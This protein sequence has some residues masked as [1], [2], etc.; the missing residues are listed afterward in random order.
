MKYKVISCA[1]AVLLISTPVLAQELSPIIVEAGKPVPSIVRSGESFEV[2][3]R[4]RYTDIVLIV[5][6]QMRF[7]DLLLTEDKDG[8]EK[9]PPINVEVSRL[10]VGEI[11][12]VGNED[13][14]FFNVQDFTYSFRIINERKGRYK[15]PSFDFI[16]VEKKAGVTAAEAKEKEE[17]RKF[18]TDEVGIAYVSTIVKPPPL[19]IRDQTRFEGFVSLADKLTYS[20]YG[21]IFLSILFTLIT[22][23]RF[24]RHPRAQKVG[25]KDS[26][27]PSNTQPDKILDTLPFKTRKE[28]VRELKKFLRSPR[29]LAEPSDLERKTVV[30][31]RGL[32]IGELFGEPVQALAS[33][34][35]SEL[36]SKLVNLESKQIKALG[37]VAHKTFLSISNKLQN[38]YEDM[39]SGNLSNLG[40]PKV[41]I[42]ELID[43]IGLIDNLSAA[44]RF[45]KALLGF[46]GQYFGG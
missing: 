11:H 20:A 1:V 25:E 31:L 13:E 22:L 10:V 9:E 38:F 45:R 12:R 44:K 43:L 40:D 32:I 17:L 5:E 33:D 21:I 8:P 23:I 41:Q 34:T 15:I 28:V 19:D 2:T 16:W 30:L 3:Y 29:I 14:G 4:V 24:F 26:V 37:T 36:R 35:P 39:E 42:R 6:E 7:S 18:P 27:E 46:L